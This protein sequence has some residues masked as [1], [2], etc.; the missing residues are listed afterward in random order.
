MEKVENI[1]YESLLAGALIRFD[2]VDE[3]DMAVLMDEFYAMYGIE[4][5]KEH[6][7]NQF[8]DYNKGVYAVVGNSEL[9]MF[10]NKVKLG[11]VQGDKV[12]A[13]IGGV[14]AEVLALRKT[15]LLGAIPKEDIKSVNF[16]EL[17]SFSKVLNEG[18]LTIRWNDDVPHDDYEEIV[19]TQ[20]GRLRLFM[21]DNCSEIEEFTK[22]L[23]ESGYDSSLIYDFLMTQDLTNGV[24]EI[25]NL[26]NF[27]RFCETYDRNRF[28]SKKDSDDKGVSYKKVPKD[29][30]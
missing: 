13:F 17:V 15:E 3:N 16:E 2:K 26:D 22:L 5:K 28:A 6:V 7:F 14:N 12:K 29:K 1:S 8:I 11:D 24:Y 18:Y 27:F 19:M 4:I 9:E 30:K 21:L 23:D 20:K 10:D 25:L